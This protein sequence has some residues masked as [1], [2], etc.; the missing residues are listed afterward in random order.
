MPVTEITCAC[1]CGSAPTSPAFCRAR[2]CGRP[3]RHRCRRSDI[4]VVASRR[5][6]LA[7]AKTTS[8]SQSRKSPP[9]CLRTPGTRSYGVKGPRGST[10]LSDKAR[11]LGFEF[12]NLGGH[13]SALDRK[14]F[15]CSSLA[16]ISPPLT[17][18][19]GNLLKV[20]SSRFHTST[21]ASA[22]ASI[23]RLS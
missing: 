13:P 15:P 19:S 3:A 1:A 10:R 8:L 5:A 9:A 17:P 18:T 12:N 22:R 21:S 11:R 2:R 6:G 23:I 7:A 16:R 14:C 20:R 4:Q